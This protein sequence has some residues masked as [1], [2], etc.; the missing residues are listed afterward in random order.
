[1]CGIFLTGSNLAIAGDRVMYIVKIYSFDLSCWCVKNYYI[2][3][4]LNIYPKQA[5]PLNT[6]AALSCL[7]ALQTLHVS[8]HITAE[9]LKARVDQLNIFFLFKDK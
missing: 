1:L 6:Y 4:K 8:F 9:S 5:P 2:N 7:A 3:Y